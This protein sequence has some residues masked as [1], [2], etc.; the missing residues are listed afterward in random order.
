MKR[1][2]SLS[3]PRKGYHHSIDDDDDNDN[4]GD[5]IRKRGWSIASQNSEMNDNDVGNN[6]NN[7][8]NNKN[9]AR[10][11]GEVNSAAAA[12]AAAHRDDLK[13]RNDH[14]AGERNLK[15]TN[16]HHKNNNTQFYRRR[17]NTDHSE[18]TLTAA[19]KMELF[20]SFPSAEEMGDHDHDRD[21]DDQGNMSKDGNKVS[22]EKSRYTSVDKKGEKMDVLAKEVIPIDDKSDQDDDDDDQDCIEMFHLSNDGNCN[23]SVS[24]ARSSSTSSSSSSSCSPTK[25]RRRLANG[26]SIRGK[27]ADADADADVDE[28]KKNSASESNLNLLMEKAKGRLSKWATRLFDPNR[29][30]GL[31]ETP[32]TIPLNDEILSAFGKR[33]RE[34]DQSKGLVLEIENFHDNN[35]HDDNNDTSSDSSN[36]HSKRKSISKNGTEV[37]IANLLYT[38]TK[39]KL[40]NKCEEYGPLFDVDLVMDPESPNLNTGRAIVIFQNRHNAEEFVE[41]MNEKEF[42][43]RKIFVN[44][45]ESRRNRRKSVDETKYNTSSIITNSNTNQQPTPKRM[46]KDSRYWIHDI[47]TKCN[48]CGEVGHKEFNCPN[49]A[50]AKPCPIC[51]RIDDTHKSQWDCPFAKICFNCGIPGHINRDCPHPRNLP[52][53]ILCTL[54]FRTGHH[55]WSCS[56]MGKRSSSFGS[57]QAKD[58]QCMICHKIGHFICPGK[59]MKWFFG[60]RGTS[61][62]NCGMEGHH[63]AECKRPTLTM[64]LR[65]QDVAF[66]EIDRAQTY[67][68]EA[69]LSQQR[70]KRYSQERSSNDGNVRGRTQERSVREQQR[71]YDRQKYPQSNPDEERRERLR[72]L[73]QPPRGDNRAQYQSST[74]GRIH[75]YGDGGGNG[76]QYGSPSNVKPFRGHRNDPRERLMSRNRGYK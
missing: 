65:D 11:V 74:Y 37:K 7:N 34:H 73:S 24:S 39:A 33:E 20:A 57:D 29:P 40:A 58:A 75:S 64:C 36:I 22:N 16:E 6:K 70:I 4:E 15:P 19:E 55:R 60:L 49:D 56:L 12:A 5:I 42:Q 48:R 28:Q 63:G 3:T 13:T 54:C 17:S 53:R 9:K 41:R 69:E 18:D 71:S 62:F 50:K 14:H 8:T 25:K 72:A 2:S 31:I 26:T 59:E 47:S 35:D 45:K 23:S 27:D 52:K 1:L 61:C 68:I 10:S 21:N 38:I 66:R 43:G 51:G 76:D 44:L 32:Q 46:N 67:S 30:R